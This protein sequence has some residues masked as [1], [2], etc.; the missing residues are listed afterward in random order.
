MYLARQRDVP[1][2]K[3]FA[4]EVRGSLA[5]IFRY[6]SQ[7]EISRI[8]KIKMITILRVLLHIPGSP[9]L[10]PFIR[11]ALSVTSRNH[12][13]KDVV[14]TTHIVASKLISCLTQLLVPMMVVGYGIFSHTITNLS[15]I[16]A[17]LKVMAKNLSKSS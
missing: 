4:R 17:Q 9:S 7:P 6:L 8:G 12:T 14:I 13:I 2:Q 16:G 1:I 11:N 5:G 10:S 15:I 3:S